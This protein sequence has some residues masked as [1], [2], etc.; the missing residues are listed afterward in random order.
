MVQPPR[1]EY[2]GELNHPTARGNAR[3]EIHLGE[4]D[5]IAF[6]TQLAE[7]VAMAMDRRSCRDCSSAAATVS[8]AATAAAAETAATAAIAGHVRCYPYGQCYLYGPA[9]SYIQLASFARLPPL[10]WVM[11]FNHFG[12]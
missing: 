11:Q 7:A 12:R 1:I 4:D 2:P 3:A 5:R 9:V 6:P 8:A 10:C